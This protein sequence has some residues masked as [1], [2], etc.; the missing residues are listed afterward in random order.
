MNPSNGDKK[1]CGTQC[2]K[3][4]KHKQAAVSELLKNVPKL[5][6]SFSGDVCKASIHK[7]LLLAM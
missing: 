6:T 1:L 4:E 7:H 2:R 5:S 3:G